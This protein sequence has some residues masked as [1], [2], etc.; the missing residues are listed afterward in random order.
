MNKDEAIRIIKEKLPGKQYGK[1]YVVK[2]CPFCGRSDGKFYVNIDTTQ[3]NCM[4][5]SCKARGNANTLFKHL[6]IS[7]DKV[8]LGDYKPDVRTKEVTF[9][10]EEY[11]VPLS[12]ENEDIIDYMKSRG[13]DYDTLVKSNVMYSTKHNALAFATMEDADT[14]VGIVY[15]KIDKKIYME[16]DS[17]QMLW[18]KDTAD[19]SQDTLFITEGRVDCLSLREIGVWNS[20]SIPNGASSHHWIEKEWDFLN[21]Y[22]KLVLCYDNDT[23][24]QNAILEIKTRLDFASLY[25]LDYKEYK[26]INEMLLGNIQALYDTVTKPKEIPMD[27]FI[28]LNTVSTSEYSGLELLS[29]GL[30]QIDRIMGGT[31]LGQSTIICAPSGVGKTVT[32]CN[33]IKGYI[34]NGE[35][36]AVWSGELNNQMLKTWLYSVFAGE[37]AIDKKP[38]PFRDGDFITSIKK[39]YEESIDEVVSDSLYIYDGEKSDGFEMVEAFTRLYK[40]FG[41]KV[42][43]IDNLSILNMSVRGLDKYQG[44]EEFAKKLTKFVKKHPIH[45]FMV[46]HPTK[47]NL[48]T[49]PNYTDKNGR[50]KRPE[51]YDQYSVKGSSALANLTHN[52]IFLQKATDHIKKYMAQSVMESMTEIGEDKT[53]IDNAVKMILKNFSLLAYAVKNRG[54]GAVYENALLGYDKATRRIYGLTSK[55]EDLS[56]EV[57]KEKKE[58]TEDEFEEIGDDF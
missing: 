39:E 54:T 56:V 15:R 28:S 34:A 44:E 30:K 13:I 12:P 46:A 17:A 37:K 51:Y 21:K 29:C 48:N 4:H 7:A 55:D 41:V 8:E 1:E 42:F 58:V 6:G 23:P 53:N 10:L 31:G 32:M 49:D 36:C 27:G 52:I 18:G 26:D 47:Q 40:R 50:I 38:H 25:T 11:C 3:Y 43:F 9:N 14:C 57:V 19:L 33:M 22:K 5:A 16:R 20:L 35:S 45:L 2:T 24:G